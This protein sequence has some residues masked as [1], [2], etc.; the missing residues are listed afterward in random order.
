MITILLEE[1]NSSREMYKVAQGEKQSV[2]DAM[3]DALIVS[4]KAA[5]FDNETQLGY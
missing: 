5:E 1:A 3:H 2:T 4:L